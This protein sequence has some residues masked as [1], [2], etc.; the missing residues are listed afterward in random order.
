MNSTSRYIYVN[1]SERV[2]IF[3]SPPENSKTRPFSYFLQ[4][5]PVLDAAAPRKVLGTFADRQRSK[6][7]TSA[8]QKSIVLHLLLKVEVHGRDVKL[9][10]G[11]VKKPLIFSVCVT[12]VSD[13]SV[14]MP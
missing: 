2:S 11:S 3:I 6:D 1:A 14:C 8:Q 10:R 7:L 9:L 4:T 5:V 13:M 12:L